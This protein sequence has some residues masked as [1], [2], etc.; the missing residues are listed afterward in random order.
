MKKNQL[1]EAIAD[2]PDC[3]DIEVAVKGDKTDNVL[4]RRVIGVER[5]HRKDIGRDIISLICLKS[6]SN[7][8]NYFAA[9]DKARSEER[10]RI[11]ADAAMIEQPNDQPQDQQLKQ[12]KPRKKKTAKD[13]GKADKYD[14]AFDIENFCQGAKKAKTFA[15]IQSMIKDNLNNGSSDQADDRG[16]MHQQP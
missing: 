16:G 5:R 3:L 11:I 15:D 9:E 10:K 2:A 12:R 1:I 6:L 14:S 13:N 4:Y 7:E 8:R